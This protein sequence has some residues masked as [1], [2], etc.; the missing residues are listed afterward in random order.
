MGLV[1]VGIVGGRAAVGAVSV[2]GTVLVAAIFVHGADIVVAGTKRQVRYWLELSTHLQRVY[3]FQRLLGMLVHHLVAAGAVVV[4]V[5]PIV[6]VSILNIT[7]IDRAIVGI[8]IAE[9][10]CQIRT[11]GVAEAGSELPRRIELEL[12]AAI[13][14]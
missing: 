3:T 14:F 7:G 5:I 4:G 13:D 1:P 10:E 11:E 6:I 9:S 2:E 8:L 12:I